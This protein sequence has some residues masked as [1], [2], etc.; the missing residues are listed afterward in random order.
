MEELYPNISKEIRDEVAMAWRVART[1]QPLESANFINTY[2][3]YFAT[4]HTEEETDFVRFYFNLQLEMIKNE[5]SS[6]IG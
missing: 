6:D 1:M 3:N 4:H 5:V 2:T